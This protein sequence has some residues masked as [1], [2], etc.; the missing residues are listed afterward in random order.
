MWHVALQLKRNIYLLL[1]NSVCHRQ[2]IIAWQFSNFHYSRNLRTTVKKELNNFVLVDCNIDN[3]FWPFSTTRRPWWQK[4]QPPT[5]QQQHLLLQNEIPPREVGPFNCPPKMEAIA[6]ML[7]MTQLIVPYPRRIA[8]CN[9]LVKSHFI[10][11][12]WLGGHVAARRQDWL[13]CIPFWKNEVR[14]DQLKDLRSSQWIFR[15]SHIC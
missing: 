15:V 6:P 4:R 9:S 2:R 7:W 12:S 13:E 5:P 10:N 11:S 1:F 8:I 14:Q 3:I